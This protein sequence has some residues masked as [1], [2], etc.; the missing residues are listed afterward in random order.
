MKNSAVGSAGHLAKVPHQPVFISAIEF[1]PESCFIA[2][3]PERLYRRHDR[4]L[5]SEAL[6]GSTPRTGDAE[7]D[8]E[9]ASLLLQDGKNRL[10]NRFVHTDILTRLDGLADTAVV[11]GSADPTAEN[12]SSISNGN[13]SH[14]VAGNRRLAIVAKRCT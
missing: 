6:A 1:S 3:S 5:F 2:S 11:S 13:R 12:I 14:V 10:E 4:Q 7:Q 8:A 9:L